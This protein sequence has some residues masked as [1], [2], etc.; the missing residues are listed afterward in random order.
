[1]SGAKIWTVRDI[2]DWTC[3]YLERKGDEHPRLSAEWLLCSAL[4]I[5]R[6]QVYMNF[7]EPLN[8]DELTRMREGV[9]RRAQGEPLQYV[10]GEMPFRHI[11]L[12]CKPKVLIPRPETEILVDKCL[13]VAKAIHDQEPVRVLEIGTGTGCISCSLAYEA[14]YTQVVATDIS[15]DAFELARRNV[16][17]LGLESQVEVNLCDLVAGLDDKDKDNFDLIVSNPPYIP[18]RV[19][20]ELPYEVQGFE[21]HLALDGGADGLDVYRR[22]LAEATEY[23]KSGGYLAVELFEE[24]LEEASRLALATG[25]YDRTEIVD[26]LTHRNRIIL[27]HKI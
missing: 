26:D 18:S 27:A 7:D 11:V 22:I 5:S 9:K 15:P 17:A 10:T 1:M 6:I 16:D 21:P 24:S 13:E 3:D 4:D 2:M 20:E 25:K 19:M 8:A 14:P 12:Q 23:L